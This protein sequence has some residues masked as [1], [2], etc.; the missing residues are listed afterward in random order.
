MPTS[1]LTQ[2]CCHRSRQWDRLGTGSDGIIMNNNTRVQ[3]FG[4]VIRL[5]TG[6]DG[7]IVLGLLDTVN[8][9]PASGTV[10]LLADRSILAGAGDLLD[11]NIETGSLA[12]TADANNN[13][14]GMIGQSDTGNGTPR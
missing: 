14:T 11:M 8:A 3:N 2:F 6:N 4:G 10:K 7:D 5:Q 9:N 13:A 12:M 1:L